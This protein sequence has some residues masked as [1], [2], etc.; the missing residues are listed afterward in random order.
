MHLAGLGRELYLNLRPILL[1]D[2]LFVSWLVEISQ[3]LGQLDQFISSKWIND[4]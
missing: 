4:N 2:W 3:F 1:L